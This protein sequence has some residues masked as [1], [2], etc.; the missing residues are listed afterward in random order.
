M[1][2]SPLVLCGLTAA[3]FGT[4]RGPE[5]PRE[6]LLP[7]VESDPDDRRP[8]GEPGTSAAGTAPGDLP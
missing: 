2:R 1:I 7:V 5:D 4:W 8:A 3:L 6:A